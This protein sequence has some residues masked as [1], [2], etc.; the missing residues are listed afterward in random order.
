MKTSAKVIADSIHY[1]QARDNRITTEVVTMPRIILAELNTHRVLSKNSASSRAIPYKKMLKSIMTNP[2]VPIAMQKDHS[3]M[4]G[5]EYLDMDKPYELSEVGDSIVSLLAK[6]FNVDGEK[7]P[8]YDE[9]L[10]V[11][12]TV[13]FP[14]LG[15]MAGGN[16]LTMRNW[17]LKIRDIVA[18]SSVVLVA[19]GVTKQICN[20]LLEPFMWHTVII[21]ATEWENFFALRCPR[22]TITDKDGVVLNVYRSK[23]D[24]LKDHPHIGLTLDEKDNVAWLSF[25][26]G[27]AEIHM[28]ELAECIY[29]ALNESTPKELQPGEWHVPYGD[30]IDHIN[31]SKAIDNTYPELSQGDDR[32]EERDY[33]A[34]LLKVSTSLNAKTSY[35]TIT[36]AQSGNKN[37]GEYVKDIQLHDKLKVDGHMSPFE[38]CAQ[39]PTGFS[40]WSGNFF[41]WIQYRKTL[42]G[43]FIGDPELV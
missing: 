26:K 31:L 12:N 16:K 23:K 2:F 30:E 11:L 35:T 9:I 38:H 19:F 20:R 14:I 27:M 42:K 21:T 10:N 18:C 28:M 17:W 6:T 34:N 8:E 29:D 32:S 25:N 43:E 1:L 39:V 33:D 7:D 22:Y 40:G 13:L 3:G 5:T 41:N 4:Q 37:S 36:T 24:V 15:E